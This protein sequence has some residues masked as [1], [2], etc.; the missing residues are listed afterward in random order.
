MVLN[1]VRLLLL[2][3]VSESCQISASAQV[4]FKYP[5]PLDK[6][7]VTCKSPNDYG[8]YISLAIDLVAS[9]D[10]YIIRAENGTNG[11][12]LAD[13]SIDAHCF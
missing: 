12:N 5:S 10:I 13:F 4:V 6:H 1:V 11:W 9:C 2:W 7:T 8:W 3:L